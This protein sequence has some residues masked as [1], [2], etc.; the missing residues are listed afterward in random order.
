[1]FS[2]HEL[3]PWHDFPYLLLQKRQH[4]IEGAEPGGDLFGL[5]A[6]MYLDW[7]H[8][9]LPGEEEMSR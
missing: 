5:L 8:F 4:A 1:M 7:L 2:L 6:L 9:L 3:R